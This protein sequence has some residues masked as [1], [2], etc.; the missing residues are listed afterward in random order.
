MIPKGIIIA[1]DWLTSLVSIQNNSSAPM[2]AYT[3]S[4]GQEK[5]SVIGTRAPNSYWEHVWEGI[6]LGGVLWRVV[7]R[8]PMAVPSAIMYANNQLLDNYESA[9]IANQQIHG[10]AVVND[11]YYISGQFTF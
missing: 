11:P 5:G 9:A 10:S 4:R 8:S 7:T 6:K 1:D 3:Y 2:P